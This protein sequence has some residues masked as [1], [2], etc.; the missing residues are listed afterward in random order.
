MMIPFFLSQGL[1]L[2]V[3]T[4]ID[5]SHQLLDFLINFRHLNCKEELYVRLIDM[6]WKL[7][8]TK[9]GKHERIGVDSTGF[10]RI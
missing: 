2:V 1:N 9:M 8:T 5:V 10:G 3:P 7:R 4:L 6:H